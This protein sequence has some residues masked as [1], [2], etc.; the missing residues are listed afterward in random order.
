[1]KEKG[2]SKTQAVILDLVLQELNSKR[3]FNKNKH[4]VWL[5]NLFI[6]VKLLHQL[7]E[8]GIGAVGTIQTT[9]TRCKVVDEWDTKQME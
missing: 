3:Y 8:E 9:K 5:D 4:I 1:M 2:F 7:R 6:S